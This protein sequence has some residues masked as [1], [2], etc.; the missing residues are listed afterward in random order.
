M[1]RQCTHQDRA[2]RLRWNSK[3]LIWRSVLASVPKSH[4]GKTN[5]RL[6]KHH[7]D[8]ERKELGITGRVE[9]E[10][11]SNAALHAIH[12]LLLCRKADKLSL[13]QDPGCQTLAGLIRRGRFRWA[14][15]PSKTDVAI[16]IS[17]ART[18]VEIMVQAI[19]LGRETAPMGM[20]W[21]PYFNIPS[22]RR[23]QAR[24]PDYRPL[25]HKSAY[26]CDCLSV[27]SHRI[28]ILPSIRA[29]LRFYVRGQW[30]GRW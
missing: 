13:S 22:G 30:S 27:A 29:S 10:K 14:R 15:W 17:L 28:P 3:Y 9:G 12:G 21:H 24:L 25:V 4:K 8:L 1:H 16:S 26:I 19:N 23:D 18:F 2:E 20:R 6:Q 11:Q 5:G 7:S